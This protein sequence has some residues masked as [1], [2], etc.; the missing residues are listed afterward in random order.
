MSLKPRTPVPESL[1]QFEAASQAQTQ[2]ALD[3]QQTL[4]IQ[5]GQAQQQDA[6][7]RAMGMR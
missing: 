4:Q 2:K 3:Q 5:Q 7:A 1:Q 6:Q